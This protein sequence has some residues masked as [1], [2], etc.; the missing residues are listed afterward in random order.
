MLNGFGKE[1]NAT[2]RFDQ[3]MKSLPAS[4]PRLLTADIAPNDA[5]TVMTPN[6]TAI[7]T[8]FKLPSDCWETPARFLY[9]R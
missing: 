9:E 3:S 4:A 1:V 7:L 8:S 2:P 6:K 5:F